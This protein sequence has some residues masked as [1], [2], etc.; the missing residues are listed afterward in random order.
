MEAPTKQEIYTQAAEKRIDSQYET[1]E[2]TSALE[3]QF[4]CWFY[5]WQWTTLI[6]LLEKDIRF[7]KAI[8]EK[9]VNHP[10][11]TIASS[12]TRERYEGRLRNLDKI[13]SEIMSRMS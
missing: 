12:Q 4:E 9:T 3:R 1:Y 6:E 7:C 11:L 10:S 2:S 5:E 8:I 13:K